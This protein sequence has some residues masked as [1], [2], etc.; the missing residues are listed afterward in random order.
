MTEVVE[1]RDLAIA[2]GRTHVLSGVSLSV[3]AGE[4]VAVMGP[5]G[6]GKSTLLHCLAGLLQPDSGTVL[7][8]GKPLE[9]LRESARSELRLRRMGFVFQFGDL[10]PELTLVENVE[11]P[12]TLA[13]VRSGEARRRA[14]DWLE[15]LEIAEEGDRRLTEVSGG[16]AQRAAVARALIHE[17]AVVF[18]DEPTGSLD[19]LAGETVL[20][21]LTTT[22]RSTGAAVLLVTHEVRVASY[23]RR[24]ISLRDGRIEEYAGPVP[25]GAQDGS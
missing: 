23:A 5:S 19:T 4:I 7:F 14:L 13:G 10:I 6:S 11:L 22:A 25:L 18:A 8:Q 17:P 20:E 21:A 9:G 2:F 16:Q 24:E 15:R 3:G 12:L 1:C